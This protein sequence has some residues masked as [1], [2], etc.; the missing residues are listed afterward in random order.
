[1]GNVLK[2]KPQQIQPS[3]SLEDKG[4]CKLFIILPKKGYMVPS[5]TCQEQI[6]SLPKSLAIT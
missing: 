2:K 4:I 6:K 1:M 5:M 3:T